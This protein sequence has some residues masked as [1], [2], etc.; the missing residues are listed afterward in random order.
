MRN[1]FLPF[2]SGANNTIYLQRSSKA[3]PTSDVLDEKEDEFI[4]GAHQPTRL[5]SGWCCTPSV[6]A[7]ISR[8]L[9]GTQW[10]CLGLGHACSG[11]QLH[12]LLPYS[13]AQGPGSMTRELGC[14][15]HCLQAAGC[16]DWHSWGLRASEV[17]P[18]WGHCNYFFL[19]H[20]N[21]GCLIVIAVVKCLDVSVCV[22]CGCQ[23][24]MRC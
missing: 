17:M 4:A 2:S 11:A 13:I 7:W 12:P 9:G 21:S 6:Y 15:R 1:N 19:V 18:A 3:L 8:D 22:V 23:M 16:C 24:C 20:H 14:M 5:V 10:L